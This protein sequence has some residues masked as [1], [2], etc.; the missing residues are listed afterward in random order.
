MTI[1]YDCDSCGSTL[2]IKE[3]LAGTQG[4]CPKCKTAFTVP[5]PSQE[6]GKSKESRKKP[7]ATAKKAASSKSKRSRASDDD[8]DPMAVLMDDDR[9]KTAGGPDPGTPAAGPLSDDEVPSDLDL[10]LSFDEEAEDPPVKKAKKRK[11]VQFDSDDEMD[12]APSATAAASAGG[13]LS[14]GASSGAAKDLLTKTMEESRARASR[15]DEEPQREGPAIGD[16]LREFG[17]QGG[18]IVGG[19]LLAAIGLYYLSDKMMGGGM[20]LPDLGRVYGT[21]TLD[22]QPLVGAKVMFTPADRALRVDGKES[23]RLRTSTAITDAEGYYELYYAEDIRG[24]AVT[25]HRVTID[26]LV[27]S[28]E[29]MIPIAYTLYGDERRVVESGRNPIDFPLVSDPVPDPPERRR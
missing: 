18:A 4:K 21:V 12:V 19:F 11:R 10:E 6:A 3:E 16:Y 20:D 5:E 22:G 28:R 17:P 24:A 2:N 27:P 1:R 15:V 29:V 13:M 25:E 7:V 8:F 9:G 26:M 23:Q 14:S